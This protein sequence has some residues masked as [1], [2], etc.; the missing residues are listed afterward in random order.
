MEEL[1]QDQ[2]VRPGSPAG[3]DRADRGVPQPRSRLAA[4]CVLRHR[5]SSRH[6]AC[7]PNHADPPAVR[8]RWGPALW[9]P[10]PV[11]PYLMGELARSP[12]RGG[13][14]PGHPGASRRRGEP[15][16][17]AGGPFHRYDHGFTPASGL[18][19]GTRTG[20]LDPGLVRFLSRAEGMTADAVPQP[21]EPRSRAC[22]ASRRPALT[23]AI[24]WHGR[25]RCPG[26]RGDRVVL[27]PG[28][29]VDR[30]LCRRARRIGHLGFRRGDR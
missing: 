28:Q 30:R 10:W 18:V 6:A 21:R 1:R 5:V 13:P 17:G 22:S 7:G 19:M 11:L 20:D 2:P 3:R 23:C 4:G 15:G 16:G 25:M 29:E 12:A 9:L 26:G 14:R 27:L 24:C 8:G